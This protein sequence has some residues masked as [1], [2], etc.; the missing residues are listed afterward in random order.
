MRKS[1]SRCWEEKR[2]FQ[3]ENEATEGGSLGRG[4]KNHEQGST[5]NYLLRRK[6]KR[7]RLIKTPGWP[8]KLVAGSM[9]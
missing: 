5:L 2:E 7:I 3:D 1:L 6:K 9:V 4:E 8:E